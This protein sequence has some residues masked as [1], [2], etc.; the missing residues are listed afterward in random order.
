MPMSNKEEMQIVKAWWKEYGIYLLF[1]VIM[2]LIV[3][4]GWRYWQRYNYAALESSSTLYMQM[5]SFLD[6]QK[7]DEFKLFGERLVKDYSRTPY[8]SFAALLL[9]KEAVQAGDLKSAKE[10]LQFVIKKGPSKKIRDIARIRTARVLIAMEKPKDALSLL[11]SIDDKDYDASASEVMGDAFLA[12]GQIKE[13]ETAY[14]K[15]EHLSK[16]IT[17]TLPLLKLKMQQ[18]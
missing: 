12:L 4:F 18:F 7:K 8:A 15:A 10:K 9:A 11:S 17:S 6:Q 5:L 13:A 3:N 16:D 14:R 1:T 2:F